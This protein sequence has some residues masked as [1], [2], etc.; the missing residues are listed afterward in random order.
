MKTK[1]FYIL[2]INW[3]NKDNNRINNRN[4]TTAN[5]LLLVKN[6]IIIADCTSRILQ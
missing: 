4:M 1:K 3:D 6:T 5:D 2:S